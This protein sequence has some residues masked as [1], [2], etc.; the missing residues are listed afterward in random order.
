MLVCVCERVNECVCVC[1]YGFRSFLP[2]IFC[3]FF[4]LGSLVLHHRCSAVVRLPLFD[5][6]Y[7]LVMIRYRLIK[8]PPEHNFR[9][10]S[11]SFTH[12]QTYTHTH[13]IQKHPTH[14]H[15]KTNARMTNN[16]SHTTFNQAQNQVDIESFIFFRRF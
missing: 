4:S 16:E 9:T 1:V 15:H 3:V 11:H 10:Y 6:S 7:G 8:F 14:M 5:Y 13:H 12:T 2:S